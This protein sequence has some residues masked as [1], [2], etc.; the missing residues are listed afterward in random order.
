MNIILLPIIPSCNVLKCRMLEE[1]PLPCLVAAVT[2][3]AYSVYFCKSAK[4]NTTQKCVTDILFLPSITM[5]LLSIVVLKILSVFND[6]SLTLIQYV[7]MTPF[8]SR[9]SGGS[10]STFT[11]V[12]DRT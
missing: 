12:E 2:P 4:K 9:K 1:G 11:E 7:V 5:N 3:T 8:W 10:Q 6:T